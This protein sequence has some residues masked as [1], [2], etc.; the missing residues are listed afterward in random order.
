MILS[1]LGK[2]VDHPGLWG[3]ENDAVPPPPLPRA[4]EF[5]DVFRDGVSLL[6]NY[7]IEAAGGIERI[8][9]TAAELSKRRIEEMKA[10]KSESLTLGE[11]LRVSMWKGFTNQV[12]SPNESPERSPSPE[13]LQETSEEESS[14]E[15]DGNVTERP[16]RDEPPAQEGITSRLATTVWRG[17]TNQSSMEPP[18]SPVPPPS[19]LDSA[20]DTE[21]THPSSV[22]PD[23]PTSPNGSSGFWKYAE[24][25]KDSDTVATLSKV[26]SNWR[27]KSLLGSWGS[28][29]T[30][31]SPFLSPNSALSG[32]S[33]SEPPE[34]PPPRVDESRR[35]SLPPAA[36]VYSPPPRPAFF[37]QPRDSFL[38][39]SRKSPLLSL[40]NS[41]ENTDSE[42]IGRGQRLQASLMALTGGSPDPPRKLGPRPLLLGSSSVVTASPRIPRSTTST[43]APEFRPGL[44]AARHLHRDSQSSISSFSLSP[45]EG[46]G[47]LHTQERSNGWDSDTLSRVVPLNR[48][49]VSPMAPGSR[50]LGPPPSGYSSASDR[51]VASPAL[52]TGIPTAEHHGWTQVDSP[53]ATSA[54]KTPASTSGDTAMISVV[55]DFDNGAPPMEEHVVQFDQPTRRI[56]RKKT[57]PPSAFIDQTSDSSSTPAIPRSNRVKSRRSARPGNLRLQE[58]TERRGSSPNSLVVEWPTEHDL[59]STPKASNF[60]PGYKPVSPVSVSPRSPRRMRK[61]SGE[62]VEP[63]PRKLSAEIPETRVRKVSTGSRGR[64]TSTDK[65]I[66]RKER[67]SAAEEG[68]D[69]GYDDLLSAYESE[70]GYK[71]A[72]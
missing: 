45:A 50:I 56:I 69:E 46:F 7:P 66:H 24:K 67:D 68:D 2:G 48:K 41:P 3:D 10:V 51:G 25:L 52:A 4:W 8:L 14:S 57:P 40:P 11:R 21:S 1:S 49:S 36:T 27:A 12:S 15:D 71:S 38:P 64:K 19:P 13:E 31:S 5:E 9:Q 30:P 61:V 65:D 33:S 62:L 35:G 37:R 58:P 72:E 42:S 43:P 39:H 53:T 34:M 63:R 26:S 28:R 47:R 23:T 18:P 44:E 54:P 17:I 55:D 59:A 16:S 32:S 70:G 20:H 60:E 6:Q 22:G 29:S